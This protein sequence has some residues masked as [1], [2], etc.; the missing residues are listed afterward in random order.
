MSWVRGH[1]RTHPPGVDSR[2]GQWIVKTFEWFMI[3][4]TGMGIISGKFLS[5]V[6]LSLASLYTP[7]NWSASTIFHTSYKVLSS[8]LHNG[9]N[10]IL[11]LCSGQHIPVHSPRCHKGEV[12][13]KTFRFLSNNHLKP[14]PHLHSPPNRSTLWFRTYRPIRPAR[15]FP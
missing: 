7:A 14:H 5:I 13:D 11:H 15:A 1:V 2:S 12:G 3:F 4:P 6:F 9:D 8:P 10:F